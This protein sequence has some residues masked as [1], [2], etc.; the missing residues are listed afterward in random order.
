MATEWRNLVHLVMVYNE[1]EEFTKVDIRKEGMDK[2][3]DRHTPKYLTGEWGRNKEGYSTL[4]YN[5]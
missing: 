4:R 2:R 1:G 5:E 3:A